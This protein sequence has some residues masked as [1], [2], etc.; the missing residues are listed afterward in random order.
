MAPYRNRR[1]SVTLIAA[2][3]LLGAAGAHA[4][5]PDSRNLPP[6]PADAEGL[7][8]Q[9]SSRVDEFYLRPGATF[10]GYRKVML[11]SFDIT[12]PKLWEREHHGVDERD[13]ARFR[14]GLVKLSRDEF[15]RTLE[16]GG[17]EVVDASGPGVLDVRATI[18]NLDIRAPE[19]NDSTVRHSYVL[20]AGEGTLIA[21]LRD[22]QTGTLLARVVDRREMRDNPYFELA[23]DIT[24]SRDAQQLV[25]LWSNLLRRYLD[26][27]GANG[28][29]S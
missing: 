28:K 25:G 18:A 6:P 10:T 3:L 9:S 24:N 29:G 1:A 4:L 12:F 23:N 16:R 22:S 14:T 20:S 2:A 19:L 15:A 26:A 7:Q 13:L 21:E 11:G 27:A 17:Y 5:S 8:R